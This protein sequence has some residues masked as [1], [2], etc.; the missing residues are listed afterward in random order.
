MA[1]VRSLD[2]AFGIDTSGY[3]YNTDAK[4]GVILRNLVEGAD[5]VMS[6]ITHFY[7]LAALDYINTD[8]SGCPITGVPPWD[9]KDNDSATMV[10]TA[11]GTTGPTATALILNYVKALNIRRKAHQMAALIS[12]KHPCQ[13]ILLPGGVTS[14][15]T[16]TMTSEFNKLLGDPTAI[17]GDSKICVENSG[18]NILSFINHVYLTDVLTVAPIIL[19]FTKAS[20]TEGGSGVAKYLA[21]GTFPN[22]STGTLYIS[23]GFLNATNSSVTAGGG[24]TLTPFDQTK[25]K[26]QIKYSYYDGGVGDANTNLHPSV[27]V[28]IPLYGKANAYTWAKAPRY[29]DNVAEVGPLA[30]VLINY[31]SAALHNNTNLTVWK[32]TV[33]YVMDALGLNSPNIIDNIPELRSVIGRHAARLIEAKVIATKMSEWL[34]TDLGSIAGTGQT[35]TYTAIPSGSNRTGYGLTEAPR[36]A[37]GH[38]IRISGKKIANY[39]C[40]VPTTWNVSPKDDAGVNGPIEKALIGTPIDTTANSAV[41][42]RLRVGRIIRSFDP[43]IACTVHIVTPDRKTIDKFEVSP[44][45]AR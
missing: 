16:S 19:G 26:E 39:Q 38:W 43:C 29:N 13:P 36:G 44:L 8:Y 5:L 32:D 37:L 23:S 30:R 35:Y 25:I 4:K 2:N 10:P 14:V 1:S 20:A 34:R 18:K 17:S 3:G 6:H 33:D 27:G 9:P 45:P 21:Y 7:H 41:I 12:G 31:A 40:V 42:N 24:W 22:H 15:V 28:T 11:G